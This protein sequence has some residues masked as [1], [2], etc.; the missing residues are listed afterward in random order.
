[1]S[2]DPDASGALLENSGLANRNMTWGEVWS[3]RIDLARIIYF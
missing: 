3:L 1:M 2:C